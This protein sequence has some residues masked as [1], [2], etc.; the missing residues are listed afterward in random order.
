MLKELQIEDE[1]AL[2]F[3]PYEREINRQF[4]FAGLI[5]TA[6]ILTAPLAWPIQF[7]VC[8]LP[9]LY[10]MRYT[11][12]QAYRTLKE[13]RRLT[14][15]SLLAVNQTLI[16]FGGLYTLGGLIFML[17]TMGQ[18]INYISEARS[19][20]QMVNIFG[21]LPQKVWIL[22]NG[23]EIEIPFEQLEVGHHVAARPGQRLRD[24]G[25]F[26]RRVGAAQFLSGRQGD[27]LYERHVAAVAGSGEDLFVG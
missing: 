26:R 12:I 11:Y 25:K 6:A 17:T 19:R 21:K 9:A 5:T 14:F 2:E 8:V 16:W 1:E 22:Q 23:I 7:L 10:L 18:K 27:C 3:T 13:E 24:G 4:A 15:T 20:T